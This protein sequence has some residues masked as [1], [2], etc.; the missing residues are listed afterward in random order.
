MTIS[1]DKKPNIN[2]NLPSN[3]DLV[4]LMIIDVPQK[5]GGFDYKTRR[6]RL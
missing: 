4:I 5:L 2:K 3:W 6:C 1:P